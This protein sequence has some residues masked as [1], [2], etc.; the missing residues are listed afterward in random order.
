M[1]FLKTAIALVCTLA[2]IGCGRA[3]LTP[4]TLEVGRE[5][6]AYCRMTVSDSH[7]ASQ[8]LAPGELPKFFDD[9]GCLNHFLT[10]TTEVPTGSVIYVTDHRTNEWV[11]ADTAVFVR[12]PALATPMG[13][14]LVAYGSAELRAA[15]PGAAGGSLVAIAEVVPPA[16]QAPRGQR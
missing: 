7:L 10:G 6:C 1:T 11:A 5:A 14:H 16:W 8:V 15:D 4:A 2:A 9:L 13:S 3:E 12:V